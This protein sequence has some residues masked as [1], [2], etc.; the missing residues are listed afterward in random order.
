MKMLEVQKPTRVNRSAELK[1]RL[2]LSTEAG[3]DDRHTWQPP[4]FPS[5]LRHS[6]LFKLQAHI[7]RL[8]LLKDLLNGQVAF[9]DFAG[10]LR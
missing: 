2:K 10:I 3:R 6:E 8:F 5:A 4:S 9:R 7:E 1:E